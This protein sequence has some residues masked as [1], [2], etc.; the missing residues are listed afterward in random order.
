MRFAHI[1]DGVVV[2]ISV[3]SREPTTEERAVCSELLVD[4]TNIFCGLG[5]SYDAVL[6]QFSEPPV[7]LEQFDG[8]V[9]S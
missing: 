8:I 1:R 4:V 9:D 6:G 7:V 2:N 5:W 3:W